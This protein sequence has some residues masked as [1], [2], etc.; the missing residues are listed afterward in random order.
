MSIIARGVSPYTLRL[1]FFNFLKG[2]SVKVRKSLI[3]L[4][5]ENQIWRIKKTFF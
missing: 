2:S 5:K 4:H 1:F 3:K